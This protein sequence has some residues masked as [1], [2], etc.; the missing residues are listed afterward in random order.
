MLMVLIVGILISFAQTASWSLSSKTSKQTKTS[1]SSTTSTSVTTFQHRKTPSILY[2]PLH[3]HANSSLST[4]NRPN[5]RNSLNSR[6]SSSHNSLTISS[7]NK[8]DDSIFITQAMSHDALTS[9]EISDFYNVPI[10]SDI[11]AL[12]IDVIRPISSANNNNRMI[13]SKKAAH[14]DKTTLKSAVSMQSTINNLPQLTSVSGSTSM[15]LKNSTK[16]FRRRLKY[17]RNNKKRKRQP[18]SYNG[19]CNGIQSKSSRSNNGSCAATNGSVDKRHSVPENVIVEP[20]HMTLDEVKRFYTNLYSSSSESALEL[21]AITKNMSNQFNNNN[22]NSTTNSGRINKLTL[23][24][25]SCVFSAFG[26]KTTNMNNNLKAM[27][28]DRNSNL[29]HVSVTHIFQRF[30]WDVYCYII[31]MIIYC[32]FSTAIEFECE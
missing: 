11:Y 9:R 1:S 16:R 22:E 27:K 4:G 17:V 30:I 5:S 6:L 10:D 3:Y 20:M 15:L 14:G 25:A 19:G 23:A 8:A 18:Q 28:S 26:N 24:N 13:N 12:P 2:S 29:S 31:I 32:L 7:S 21:T